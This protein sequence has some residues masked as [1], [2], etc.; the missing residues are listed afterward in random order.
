MKMSDTKLRIW[1]QPIRTR[2]L[3]V[4]S[5]RCFSVCVHIVFLRLWPCV[6]STFDDQ[7]EANMK[8]SQSLLYIE[9]DKR[10]PC[11]F[12]HTMTINWR[13]EI[14]DFRNE[15]WP[16]GCTFSE[17]RCMGCWIELVR[18]VLVK[19]L[20]FI[21]TSVIVYI[22]YSRTCLQRPFFNTEYI[23]LNSKMKAQYSRKD[24]QK[25]PSGAFCMSCLLY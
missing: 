10:S 20:I 23:W 11:V 21:I 5:G 7:M 17:L 9:G 8:L 12:M 19:G 18:G 15:K 25:A 6:S 2:V 22:I 4:R 3:E 14:V 1:Q 13:Y 24:M 16:N